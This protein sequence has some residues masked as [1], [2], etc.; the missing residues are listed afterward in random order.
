[1]AQ[2]LCKVCHGWHDLDEPWPI[3]CVKVEPSKRSAL[4]GPAF[5]GDNIELR[6]MADGQIYTSKRALRRSYRERGYIEVGDQQQKTPERPKPD[7]NATRNSLRKAFSQ[8][9]I[10]V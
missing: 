4:P 8:A 9:G 3:E 5:I 1:M 6:S 10:P 2:R 7:P